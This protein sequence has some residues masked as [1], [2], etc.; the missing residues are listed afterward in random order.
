[1]PV[2]FYMTYDKTP[3]DIFPETIKQI[4]MWSSASGLNAFYASK[5]ILMCFVHHHNYNK[6][7]GLGQQDIYFTLSSYI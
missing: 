5:D 6:G 1:M 3:K 2:M 7:S 4:Q